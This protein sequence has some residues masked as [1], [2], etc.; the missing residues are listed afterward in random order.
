MLPQERMKRYR[1][2]LPKWLDGTYLHISQA[3]V[4]QGPAK[5]LAE[6]PEIRSREAGAVG[7]ED[8]V[9][10]EVEV[11]DGVEAGEEKEEEEEG[12]RQFIA[13]PKML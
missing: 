11:E 3:R 4:K 9:G 7:G 1:Q 12:E 10:V 6:I 8:V 5:S 2:H 13:Q